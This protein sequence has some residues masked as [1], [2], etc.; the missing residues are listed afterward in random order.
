M[1]VA[2]PLVERAANAGYRFVILSMTPATK[3]A[4]LEGGLLDDLVAGGRRL[5]VNWVD[6][7]R[8]ERG[9]EDAEVIVVTWGQDPF[10]PAESSVAPVKAVKA[11]KPKP[12]R[13]ATGK[14]PK[15]ASVKPAV[16]ASAAA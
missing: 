5:G 2:G 1:D 4:V 13:K 9:D 7:A 14:P 3:A 16:A 11:A 6:H 10:K 12:K 15:V 8:R